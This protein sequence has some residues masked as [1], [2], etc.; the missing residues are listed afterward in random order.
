MFAALTDILKVFITIFKNKQ[1]QFVIFSVAGCWLLYI[2]VKHI[3]FRELLQQVKTGNY[4]VTFPVMLVSIIGYYFRSL[5]WKLILRNMQE[6]VSVRNLYASLSIGY[7]VNFATPRLG[8]ITR[9]LVLK[10]SSGVSLE[11]SLISV[12][13]ERVI[14][15]VSLGLI[16]VLSLL[17]SR[18]ELRIFVESQLMK[19]LLNAFMALPLGWVCAG[20]LLLMATII[21]LYRRMRT[22]VWLRDTINRITQAFKDVL[23]LKEKQSFVVYTFLIWL[24]YFLMTYLWFRIFPE[25]A[26]LGMKEAFIIMAVGS[27]GR[28]VPIQGGGMGAYHYLVSNVFAIFGVSLVTGTAMAFVIH[29]AQMILTLVLGIGSW[30]WLLVQTKK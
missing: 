15:L 30:I 20:V 16:V 13:L 3:E 29:G 7:A 4:A 22:H 10:K 6:E 9:C 17:L 24:C 1:V 2:S 8:E 26:H 12:F 5:R 27:I 21:S 18:G 11:K 14:D 28:S 23:T 19:P 25:T